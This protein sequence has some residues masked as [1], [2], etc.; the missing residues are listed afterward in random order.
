MLANQCLTKSSVHLVS[1]TIAGREEA[2]QCGVKNIHVIPNGVE[3]RHFECTDRIAVCCKR[4][5]IF[6]YAGRLS[7]EKGT[8][9][10]A[11]VFQSLL[12]EGENLRFYVAGSGKWQLKSS[13]PYPKRTQTKISG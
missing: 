2:L 9:M 11:L 12:E 8:H 10:L 1:L 3:T 13:E 7:E 4:S 5:I 6:G